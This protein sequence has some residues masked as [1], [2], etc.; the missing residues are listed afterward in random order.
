VVSARAELVFFLDTI[1]F[2]V[3][4][5]AE[6]I[7]L[8][9]EILSAKTRRLPMGKS[10]RTVETS[11]FVGELKREVY[12]AVVR[13][14]AA[15]VAIYGAFA[16]TAHIR[17]RDTWVPPNQGHGFQNQHPPCRHPDD[18]DARSIR[19]NRYFKIADKL[20]LRVKHQRSGLIGY[21]SFRSFIRGKRYNSILSA[22][23]VSSNQA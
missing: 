1:C 12:D 17:R 14:F 4:V 18:A 19:H 8:I 2:V 6:A 16:K 10:S 7:R 9:R 5:V 15:V 22:A 13:Y 11:S 20:H 23:I 3:F 21:F